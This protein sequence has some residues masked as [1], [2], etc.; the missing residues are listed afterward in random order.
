MKKLILSAFLAAQMISI[1]AWALPVV[2]ENVANLGVLTIYPDHKDPNRYYIAPN[3]AMISR[4]SQGVPVFSYFDTRKSFFKPVGIMQMTLV[5]TFTLEA[6]EVA[7]SRIIAKNPHAVFNSVPFIKSELALTGTLK[8]L[9]SDNLCN[10]IAGLID[11]EQSCILE[12]T[13]NGRYLFAKA[14]RHKLLFTTLQFNYTI[15]AVRLKADGTYEDIEIQH[16]IAV[17]IDGDQ[18]S[19]Y[20]HLIQRLDI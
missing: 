18:L 1:S 4:N 5:P 15:H 17:R 7:K 16:G 20:P 19:N 8:S 6:L 3:I 11:Q 10:H 2:N 12:L 13:S 14:I 9:F